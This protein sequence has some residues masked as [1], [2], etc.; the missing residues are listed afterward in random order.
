MSLRKLSNTDR[1]ELIESELDQ[2]FEHLKLYQPLK[3][4]Y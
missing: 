3:F 2:K 1:I 4:V